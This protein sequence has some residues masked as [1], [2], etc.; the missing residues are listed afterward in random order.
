LDFWLASR[1]ALARLQASPE[2]PGNDALVGV[3]VLVVDDSDVNLDVTKRI[4]ESK[5]A[6]VWLARNGQ[7]AFEHVQAEPHAVDVVLM[8]VQMPVLD[9]HGATRR[10]RLEL[11]LT[12]LPIIALTAGALSSERQRATVAGMDDY[13][14]KPFDAHALVWS[15]LRHVK[16]VRSPPTE[17]IEGA[18]GTRPKTALPWPEIEG[19]DSSDARVRLT[20][21]FGMFQ[22]ML[23]R[24]L[25]EFSD[26]TMPAPTND[27]AALAVQAGRMHKLVGSAGTLGATAIQQLAGEAEAACAAG[28]V[29]RA[30]SFATR[31]A[32]LLQGL[33]RSAAAALAEYPTETEEEVAPVGAEIEPHAVVDLIDLL[34]QQ[35]L[36]AMD[37]F[38]SISRQLQ[39]LLGKE[40]FE[41]VR[42][43]VDNLR[44]SDAAN[45]LEEN[46]VKKSAA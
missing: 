11:G 4:L 18:G 24:L 37:R 13:L 45:A 31:L 33:R 2:E 41:L 27:R 8:D 5:G 29:D 20:D 6:Q 28:D 17:Q 46:Q 3:R 16:P 35:S 7:E 9:G 25:D 19:I 34:R 36:S 1:E 23:K 21:D 22:A 43:H 15:I 40:S 26:V 10:I 44:F 42:S 39:C 32:G 30:T 12:E 38:S 14:I